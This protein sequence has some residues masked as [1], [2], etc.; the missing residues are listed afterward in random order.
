MY[1]GGA[2]HQQGI[3]MSITY[4]NRQRYVL[5]RRELRDEIYL[6]AIDRYHHTSAGSSLV[7]LQC[8]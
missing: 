2:R 8:Y 7:D 1:D 3:N 4:I 6:E 5:S